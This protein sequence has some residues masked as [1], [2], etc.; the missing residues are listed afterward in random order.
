VTPGDIAIERAGDAAAR[1]DSYIEADAR[2]RRAE[3]IQRG[4]QTSTHGSHDERQGLHDLRDRDDATAAG[5][6]PDARQPAK[7]LAR[8]NRCSQGYSARR[9][10]QQTCTIKATAATKISV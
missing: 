6:D 8:R 1:L 9:H 3:G 4:V 7:R 2:Q 10:L 5:A